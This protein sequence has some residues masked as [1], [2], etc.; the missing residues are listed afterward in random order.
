[1]CF[2][3]FFKFF[4][5]PKLGSYVKLTPVDVHLFSNKMDGMQEKAVILN[6]K[7]HRVANT[8]RNI[9]CLGTNGRALPAERLNKNQLRNLTGLFGLASSSSNFA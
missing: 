9:E 6:L 5:G 1:M 8:V 2:L 7:T 4:V 3:L